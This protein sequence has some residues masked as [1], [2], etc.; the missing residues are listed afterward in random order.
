MSYRRLPSM[1]S[2]GRSS[3]LSSTAAWVATVSA[4][5]DTEN[6]AS[7]P[8]TNK[9]RTCREFPT[10]LKLFMTHLSPK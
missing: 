10:R 8:S 9:P 2:A 1:V 5:A 6:G 4:S 3:A 7:K